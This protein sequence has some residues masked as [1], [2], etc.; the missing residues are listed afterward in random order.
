[1][2]KILENQ[3]LRGT[4]LTWISIYQNPIVSIMLSDIFPL[5]GNTATMSVIDVIN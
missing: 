3:K 2:S 5:T 1:M 4:Y